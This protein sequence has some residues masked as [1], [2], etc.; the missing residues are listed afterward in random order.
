[1]LYIRGDTHRQF[2]G[3]RAFCAWKKT[4][5]ADI[6][7]I[8][9][10]VGINGRN[11]QQDRILKQELQEFPITFFCLRGNHDRRPTA[12]ESYRETIRYGGLVYREEEFPDLLFAK[13]GE[14]YELNGRKAFVIDGA[15]SSDRTYR[16]EHGL[17][18]WAD[19]QLSEPERRHV[20]QQL[21]LQGWKA[22]LILSHT[23]PEKY[24]P[25]ECLQRKRKTGNPDL[26]MEAWMNQL[27]EK[28]A[29]RKWYAGHWHV[30]K[31]VTDRMEILYQNFTEVEDG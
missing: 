25:K 3:V 7:I 14:T 12:L 8:T 6:L 15:S 18:W 16:L 11:P 19:E 28:T 4:S 30:E 29:Y 10:D 27:E 23:M 9:G 1:M 20:E 22:D 24:I 21:A 17:P 26:S 13:N 5:K 2:A 31:Q